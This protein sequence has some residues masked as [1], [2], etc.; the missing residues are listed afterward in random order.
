[1][2]EITREAVHKKH[3]LQ[4]RRRCFADN[5]G[6]QQKKKNS[7]RSFSVKFSETIRLIFLAETGLD[8]FYKSQYNNYYRMIRTDEEL[9]QIQQWEEKQGHRVFLRDCLSASI[10]LDTNLVDNESAEYTHVG[11]LEHKGKRQQDQKA[12]E[13]LSEITAQTINELPFYKD[14]DLICSVPPGPSKD[15]DLPSRVT[16]LVSSKVGKKDVTGGFVYNGLKS[17]VKK[18]TFDEKWDVWEKA[19]VSFKNSAELNVND[20]SVILIDDKYQSGITIQYIAMKLQQAGAYKVYGLSFV[21][22]LRDTDNV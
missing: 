13:E 10:A 18:S 8:L 16:S 12:I 3:C 14:A 11:L 1:M 17:S 15:F 5:S 6:I 21:K 4:P 19:Q 20:K 9:H 7:S 2:E 22:T